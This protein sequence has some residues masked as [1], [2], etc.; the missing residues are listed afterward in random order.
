MLVVVAS[1]ASDF[2]VPEAVPSLVVLAQ[3]CCTVLLVDGCR[4]Q[5]EVLAA[6]EVG[7]LAP[8]SVQDTSAEAVVVSSVASP[9][10]SVG[11]PFVTGTKM[12]QK[13]SREL[14]SGKNPEFSFKF[15]KDVF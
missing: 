10:P 15:A 12:F 9:S 8:P 4:L 3:G 7:L 1:P 13:W 2:E 11:R 6:M 5:A 14:N